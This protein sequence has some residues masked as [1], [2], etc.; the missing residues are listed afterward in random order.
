M[1]LQYKRPIDTSV[2]HKDVKEI[3]WKRRRKQTRQAPAHKN[4]VGALL[5]AAH[6]LAEREDLTEATDALADYLKVSREQLYA[7]PLAEFVDK[8]EGARLTEEINEAYDEELEQEDVEFLAHV[9]SYQGRVI[10]D[11]DD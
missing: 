11:A 9:R 3:S 4:T 7:M 2:W 8:Y 6:A 1:A 5:R 10:A